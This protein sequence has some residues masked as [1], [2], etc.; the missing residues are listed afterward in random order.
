MKLVI[1]IVNRDDAPVLVKKLSQEGFSSTSFPS[2]GGLNAENCT[3]L[4]GVDQEKVQQVKDVIRACCHQRPH[5]IPAATEPPYYPP[6]PM[7]TVIS[8]A[9]IFVVEIDSFERV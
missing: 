3:V 1:S 9:T 4:V 2:I 8:G 5:Q 6:R 7:E